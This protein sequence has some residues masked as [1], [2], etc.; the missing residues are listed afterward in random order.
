MKVVVQKPEL[1]VKLK[2]V[3]V[4]EIFRFTMGSDKLYIRIFPGFNLSTTT[5]KRPT[6]RWDN[7]VYFSPSLKLCMIVD[8]EEQTLQTCDPFEKVKLVDIPS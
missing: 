1:I 8:I 3:K 6:S 5:Y 2:D 7:L 4:N